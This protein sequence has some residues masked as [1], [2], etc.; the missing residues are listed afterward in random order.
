MAPSHTPA[1]HCSLPSGCATKATV[2]NRAV[3][4][5]GA[6]SRNTLSSFVRLS[7][8]VALSPAKR[9]VCTPGAPPKASTSR[10][11]S[12]ATADMPVAVAI[13]RAFKR[14]LPSKL[15]ASS[16][17]SP[18]EAGRGSNSTTS[19]SKSAISAT[20]SGLADAQTSCFTRAARAAQQ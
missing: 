9:A 7:A 12:S 11:V 6:T 3:R 16:T 5:A 8:Y 15:S 20:L 10:P 2:R 14:A 1:A 13:A 18:T 17:I 4:C 19:R